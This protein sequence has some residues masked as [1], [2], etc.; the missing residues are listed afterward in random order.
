MLLVLALLLAV[1]LGSVH[2]V[3]ARQPQA[4]EALGARKAGCS[5]ILIVGT[6][7]GGYRTDTMM[8]FFR[9][10]RDGGA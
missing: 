4:E 3:V 2:F 5:T 9:Q 8:L 1:L 10:P 6:D 7:E